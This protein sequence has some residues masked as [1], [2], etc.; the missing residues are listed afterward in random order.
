MSLATALIAAALVAPSATVTMMTAGVDRPLPVPKPVVSSS[1]GASKAP[2]TR[3]ADSSSPV[4][5]TPAAHTVVGAKGVWSVT[6]SWQGKNIASAVVAG[7]AATNGYMPK[8]AMCSVQNT[9]LRCDAAA[10]FAPM[11]AAF[12]AKFGSHINIGQG[13]RDFAGQ[14]S[15]K[16]SWSARGAAGMAATPGKS[17]HGLGLAADLSG[18]ESKSGTAQHA[19]LV[20]NA[21]TYGWMWPCAMRPGGAGPH[22]SWHF[23]FQA[24]GLSYPDFTCKK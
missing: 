16:G 24:L 4:S 12:A 7:T 22:E 5:T 17:N 23:E 3:L 6:G 18:P 2:V 20:A 9:S 19:W 10:Y 8:S 13:Y 15:V 1:A 14:V 11:D 21:P